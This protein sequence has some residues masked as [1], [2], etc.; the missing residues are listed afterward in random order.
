MMTDDIKLMNKMIDEANVLYRMGYT[1]M[2]TGVIVAIG[3]V[4]KKK[5]EFDEDRKCWK[6]FN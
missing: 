5:P 2:S 6:K 4:A 3:N 1:E